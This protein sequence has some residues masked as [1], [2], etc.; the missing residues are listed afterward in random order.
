MF[1]GRDRL[2]TRE[3]IDAID[4]VESV[5]FILD[6]V[7]AAAK[8]IEVDLEFRSDA[9][10]EWERRARGA[11]AAHHICIGHLG[12]RLRALTPKREKPQG[13]AAAKIEAKARKH[14]AHAERLVQEAKAREQR[15]ERDRLAAA[16]EALQFARKTSYLAAFHGAAQRLL[17]PATLSRIASAA[18]EAAQAEILRPFGAAAPADVG[19]ASLSGETK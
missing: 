5:Q 11:L 10:I 13:D 9:D 3:M 2:P 7:D 4:D 16:R 19:S 17:D 6:E 1:E 12:R 15:L 14:E 18:N 8:R